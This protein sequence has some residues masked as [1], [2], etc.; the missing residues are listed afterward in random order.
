MMYFDELCLVRKRMKKNVVKKRAANTE[1]FVGRRLKCFHATQFLL[2][3]YESWYNCQ[4]RTKFFIKVVQCLFLIQ[5][6][7][8]NN[9]KTLLCPLCLFGQTF[10]F[11][12]I[13]NRCTFSHNKKRLTKL[14]NRPLKNF[15]FPFVWL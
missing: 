4:G 1:T 11:K 7:N 8:T 3:K 10:K 15:D 2:K 5:F 14:K 13:L 12:V 6:F 9:M